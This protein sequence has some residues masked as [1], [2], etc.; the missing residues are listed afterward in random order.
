MN[1]KAIFFAH[2][3]DEYFENTNLKIFK[4]LN[5]GWD[6]F[7]IGW[8]GCRLLPDSLVGKRSE[9]PCNIGLSCVG[10]GPPMVDWYS[11]DL[12]LCEAYKHKPEYEGYFFVEFDTIS[13]TSVDSFF[14]TSRPSFTTN[15]DYPMSKDWNFIQ[16]YLEFDNAVDRVFGCSGPTSCI[17][18]QNSVLKKYREK[19]IENPNKIYNNMHGELRLG[20]VLGEMGVLNR[21]REDIKRYVSWDIKHLDLNYDKKFFFHPL[22]TFPTIFIE[23]MR[24]EY[25]ID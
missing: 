10:H 24:E 3:N 12:L 7:S 13:N 22:K 17:Y 11:F 6:V 19:M 5:P 2:H 21:S 9:Y 25:N 16:K 14:D 23:K 4:L 8:E 20:T 15:I 1:N 18:F